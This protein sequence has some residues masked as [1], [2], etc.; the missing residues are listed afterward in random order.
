LVPFRLPSLATRAVV[1]Q[2]GY[3]L[4]RTLL[5]ASL[6]PEI[7]RL[8]G[9]GPARARPAAPPVSELR[10]VVHRAPAQHAP[11]LRHVWCFLH[12]D[13]ARYTVHFFPA[14]PPPAGVSAPGP[15]AAT[16]WIGAIRLSDFHQ[17]PLAYP[18]RLSLQNGSA[19]MLAFTGLHIEGRV[20]ESWVRLYSLR[21]VVLPAQA[22]VQ[23]A[24]L[25]ALTAAPGVD[26]GEGRLFGHLAAHLPYYAGAVIAAGD[27]GARYL[28]LARLQNEAGR[29]L[30]DVVQ[31]QVAAVM[32]N[33]LA[34]PLRGPGAAPA[35]LRDA[36]RRYAERPPRG[37]GEDIVVTVPVP[38]VWM[39]RQEEGMGAVADD[40]QEP[41]V[42]EHR[43]K[44]D[45]RH[46]SGE[47]TRGESPLH[48]AG[49]SR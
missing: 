25:A 32:G 1:R 34:F 38:G 33:Y 28:A 39:S 11:D 40:A 24:T 3:I 43:R 20:G 49:P 14:D 2:F 30:A 48:A 16:H 18:G 17:R 47:P 26:P 31:N 42:V 6:Q 4:R 10:L 37:A 35:L 45:A 41:M 8:L 12:V 21:D 15:P 19:A 7:D 36:L 46:L 22:Q 9:I 27:P 23:L 29:P 5:D 13:S 44:A